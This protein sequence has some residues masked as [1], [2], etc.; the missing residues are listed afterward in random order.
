[1][2]A[3]TKS[4]AKLALLVV[5]VGAAFV[6]IRYTD[7]GQSINRDTLRDW[8]ATVDPVAA[9]LLYVLVYIVWTVLLLPGVLL[10]FVGAVLFGVWEGTI[11]TWMGATVGAILAF[12]LARTLGRDFVDQLL[13]GK[14]L[15][16]DRWLREHGLMGLFIVRLVPLFPF[17]GV[18]FGCGLTNIR[19]RDYVLATAVGIVPGTFVYQYLFATFGE[20]VL[21]EGFEW[22]DLATPEVLTPL[23][24][25]ALFVVAGGLMARKMRSRQTAAGDQ[26]RPP[27]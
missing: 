17:N 8:F 4:L 10:S 2:G 7:I 21:K 18:N 20:K 25:F 22:R 27:R 13:S 23:G 11:F 14:L 15:A 3:R 19:L 12:G 1:M 16:L 9:R 6:A 5:L 26:D 24:L